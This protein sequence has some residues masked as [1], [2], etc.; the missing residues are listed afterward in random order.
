MIEVWTE[1]RKALAR[2]ECQRWA[3]TPH[4]NRVAVPGVGIDCIRLLIEILIGAGLYERRQLPFYDE[5]LGAL[6]TRNIIEDLFTSHLHA[7]SLPPTASPAF[8]DLVVC[9]CG[10]QT[11][12]VGMIIDGAF[13]HVPGRGRVGPE[14]WEAWK[15]RVQSLVRITA[16]GFKA[17]PGALTWAEILAKKG[18]GP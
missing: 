8:G 18:Q 11:N 9:Q 12:H 1:E 2:A 6:R 14:S 4:V 7:N 5:R 3:G 10:R 16:P 17:D 13:W 15:G